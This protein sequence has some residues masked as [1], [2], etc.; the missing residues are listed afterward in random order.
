MAGLLAQS[1]LRWEWVA[2]FVWMLRECKAG[3]LART[4]LPFQWSVGLVHVQRGADLA[5]QRHSYSWLVYKLMGHVNGL[6]NVGGA[7]G[8]LLFP[9]WSWLGRW[10][11]RSSLFFLFSMWPSW[12][13]NTSLLYTSALVQILKLKHLFYLFL[14]LLWGGGKLG[15]SNQLSCWCPRDRLV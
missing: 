6:L 12:I 2:G 8:T 11:G 15:I 1:W 5:H 14:L 4:L 10:G 9:S 7:L 13:F 3:P